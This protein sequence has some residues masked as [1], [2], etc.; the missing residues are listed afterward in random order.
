MNANNNKH[1]TEGKV[2]NAAIKM[3]N[4]KSVRCTEGELKKNQNYS[5]NNRKCGAVIMNSILESN[6]K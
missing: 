1:Q 2:Y 5:N 4:G 6:Q 3:R